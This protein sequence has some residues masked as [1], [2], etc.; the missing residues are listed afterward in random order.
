[1]SQSPY[2][3]YDLLDL[4]SLW[5]TLFVVLNPVSLAKGISYKTK[6][7]F[8]LHLQAMGFTEK[9]MN[10]FVGVPFLHIGKI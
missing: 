6:K 8:G 2:L 5:Q 9:T 7:N 1:M 10:T 3:E 4:P